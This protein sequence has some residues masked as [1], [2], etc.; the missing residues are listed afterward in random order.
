MKQL[1]RTLSILS[2]LIGNVFVAHAQDW[3]GFYVATIDKTKDGEQY[4]AKIE[5][6]IYKLRGEHWGQ[7]RASGNQAFGKQWAVEFWTLDNG[8]SIDCY[9]DK[10]NDELFP[11]NNTH[12]FSL[13]K[14]NG[15]L[16]TTFGEVLIA[17]IK[18][19][20]IHPG[21]T[22]KGRANKIPEMVSVQP[23]K[24]KTQPTPTATSTLPQ[25]KLPKSE[26]ILGKWLGDQAGELTKY[27]D[28]EFRIDGTG[29]RGKL[30]FEW[31]LVDEKNNPHLK[32]IWFNLLSKSQHQ[33]IF[34]KVESMEVH[35]TYTVYS[36]TNKSYKI[37]AE[38]NKYFELSEP[39]VLKIKK[40][41]NKKLELSVKTTSGNWAS[42]KHSK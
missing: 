18:H 16:S 3:A 30:D 34:S 6:Q 4:Q 42:T 31:E 19:L 10:G 14:I 8:E 28:F 9:Y 27:H 26:L 5:A 15:K 41:T 1:I 38:G 35:D 36:T 37:R 39:E 32:L 29:N 7:I 13:Y 25:R 23:T 22:F 11:K 2:L 24:A 21:F 20:D 12:L 40:L 17:I 33:A